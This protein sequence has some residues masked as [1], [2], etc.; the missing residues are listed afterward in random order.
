MCDGFVEFVKVLGA[1]SEL[2]LLRSGVCRHTSKYIHHVVQLL[3]SGFPE[4]GIIRANI[5]LLSTY[6]VPGIIL[7]IL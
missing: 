5:Y 6:N 7:H 1:G 3:V 4:T 2:V